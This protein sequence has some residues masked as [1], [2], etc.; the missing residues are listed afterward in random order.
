M[1]RGTHARARRR[2]GRVAH[3]REREGGREGGKERERERERELGYSGLVWASLGYSA[4]TGARKN[5]G[6]RFLRGVG[7]EGERELG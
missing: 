4:G 3:G 7:R 1:V 6:F 5:L 2:S